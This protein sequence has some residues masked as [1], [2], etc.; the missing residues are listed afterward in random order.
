MSRPLKVHQDNITQ[1]SNPWGRLHCCP[2]PCCPKGGEFRGESHPCACR[3]LHLELSLTPEDV[4]AHAQVTTHGKR[5]TTDNL[6]QNIPH[7]SSCPPC[8]QHEKNGVQRRA[9]F[10]PV[11]GESDASSPPPWGPRKLWEGGLENY[12]KV[13]SA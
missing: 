2:C 4:K 12:T 8:F 9:Q 10:F 1:A 7:F 3:F 13:L 6:P 5:L 11:K